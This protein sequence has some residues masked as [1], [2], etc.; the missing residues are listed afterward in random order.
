[1][2]MKHRLAAL[3][4]VF[5]NVACCLGCEPR[6][7]IMIRVQRHADGSETCTPPTPEPRPACTCQPPRKPEG[8]RVIRVIRPPDSPPLDENGFIQRLVESEAS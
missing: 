5:Q 6:P 8:G 7:N 2:A 3:E 4:R 1:M